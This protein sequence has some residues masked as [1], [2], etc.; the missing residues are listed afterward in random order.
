MTGGIPDIFP[1]VD[2]SNVKLVKVNV[3]SDI[4]TLDK[5]FPRIENLTIRNSQL[6]VG[7][8]SVGI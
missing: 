6:N 1:N 4:H 3:T 8:V 7:Q 2:E 5:K